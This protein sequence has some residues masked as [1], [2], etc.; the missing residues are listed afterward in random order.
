[1]SSLIFIIIAVFWF[2]VGTFILALALRAYSIRL[3]VTLPIRSV[4]TME[5]YQDIFSTLTRLS[6]TLGPKKARLSKRVSNEF[7]RRLLQNRMVYVLFRRPPTF[8]ATRIHLPYAYSNL[9]EVSRRRFRN[10]PD[11]LKCLKEIFVKLNWSVFRNQMLAYC[12][13][14]AEY[15]R[16]MRFP[17]RKRSHEV[18]PNRAFNKEL[19]EDL[20]KVR[21]ALEDTD[22]FGAYR[23]LLRWGRDEVFS[24]LND[25][26]L[27]S[28][29]YLTARLESM[30][31]GAEY[32]AFPED[33]RTIVKDL[34]N[35]IG[36]MVSAA[37]RGHVALFLDVIG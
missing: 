25:Q 1:M 22:V 18:T 30:V 20:G 29:A 14:L 26:E 17:D 3:R 23:I 4:I 13:Y 9:S 2:I 12:H 34:C 15:Y 19:E 8:N 28:V 36:L 16:L 31:Q 37:K 32:L 11:L 21:V 7:I 35:R 10:D 6:T 27:L 5:D 24:R 33:T